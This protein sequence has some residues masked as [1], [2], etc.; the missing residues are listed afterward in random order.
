[1]PHIFYSGGF[2]YFTPE[3]ID[4]LYQIG[5]NRRLLSYHFCKEDPKM[6]EALS[7]IQKNYGK[8]QFDVMMDSGAFTV[9]AN[10]GVS[11]NMD[12][13]A[14]FLLKFKDIISVAINLDVVTG[15]STAKILEENAVKGWE[16]LKYMESKG[17]KVLHT[18]HSAEDEKWLFKLMDEYEYFGVSKTG[19]TGDVISR[20]DRVFTKLCDKKGHCKYKIHGFGITSPSMMMRYPFYSV[21]SSSWVKYGVWGMCI[22]FVNGKFMSLGMSDRKLTLWAKK[23]QHYNNLNKSERRIWDTEMERRGITRDGLQDNRTR[24]LWN[25][26]SFLQFEDWAKDKEI[27]FLPKQTLFG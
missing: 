25:I 6:L 1:M 7:H 23:G 20:L 22:L 18:F 3:E 11:I 8:E 5:L 10:K 26:E 15:D 17:L 24:D 27:L 16:N 12:E 4:S 2:P 13:Y 9:W 19:D 14:E 21:D